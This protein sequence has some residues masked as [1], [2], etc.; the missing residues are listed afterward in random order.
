MSL[1]VA[2]DKIRKAQKSNS[3]KLVLSGLALTE[4]PSELSKLTQLTSLSLRNNQ[5]TEIK[6]LE[7]LTQLTDLNLRNN[8]IAEMKGLENLIKLTRLN[9]NN[10]RLIEIKG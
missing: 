7:Q 8:R 2:L 6:G 5:I 4:I 3:S 1:K 10:N 9:L